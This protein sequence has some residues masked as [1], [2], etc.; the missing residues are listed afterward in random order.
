L[1]YWP[2]RAPTGGGERHWD[3]SK[4]LIH[5]SDSGKFKSK[6]DFY[7]IVK[8][9]VTA[10][11][12][13]TLNTAPISR[14]NAQEG[15]LIIKDYSPTYWHAAVIVKA[16]ETELVTQAGSKPAVSPRDNEKSITSSMPR[17]TYGNSP[18]RWKFS[19]FDQ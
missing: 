15:D 3:T 6:S 14:A 9:T 12:I 18:R 11:M 4:I 16:T 19:Q 5:D 7:R 2:G 1:Q 10:R 8:S 17:K 13:G